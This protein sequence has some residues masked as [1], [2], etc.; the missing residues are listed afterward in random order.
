M[1]GL[2]GNNWESLNCKHGGPPTISQIELWQRSHIKIK[3]KLVC[4][5]ND[6]GPDWVAVAPIFEEVRA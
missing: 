5:L 6:T 4:V 3:M 2:E 1:G